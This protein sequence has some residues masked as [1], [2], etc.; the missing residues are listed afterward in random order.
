MVQASLALYLRYTNICRSVSAVVECWP[1][2]PGWPSLCLLIGL[3]SRARSLTSVGLKTQQELCSALGK[4]LKVCY[5]H[6][7]VLLAIY[8]YRSSGWKI[9]M[10]LPAFLG[11]AASSVNVF[12]PLAISCIQQYM[13]LR[14]GLSESLT[15]NSI[16]IL[17]RKK[18]VKCA[19]QF[20]CY[21]H[22]KYG[23]LTAFLPTCLPD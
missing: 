20:F 10:S 12:C 1:Y 9:N 6:N 14:I 21:H 4:S 16:P 17:K 8:Q 2:L 18:K 7:V 5:C 13:P 19:W 23:L 11:C 22:R 3:A 15:S